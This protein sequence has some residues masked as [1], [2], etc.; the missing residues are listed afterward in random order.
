[1]TSIVVSLVALVAQLLLAALGFVLVFEP[2]AISAHLDLGTTPTWEGVLFALPIAMIGF[3]GLDSFANLGE[4]LDKPS[5]DIPRPLIWSAVVSVVVFVVMS[6]V[7]LNAQP[8]H[9][10]GTFARTELGASTG[11]VDR[12]VMG[13][14]DA[15]GVSDGLEGA[16]RTLFG[17]LAGAV[18]FLAAA[19]AIAA[20]GRVAWFMSRH[21]QAPSVLFS[22]DRRTGVPRT[23]IALLTLV[24]LGLL[25]TTIS[26]S[27]SAVVL[28]QVYAFGATFTATLAGVAIIRLRWCEPDLERPFRAPGNV[29][30]RGRELP[31]LLLAG[32]V[33]SGAMWIIVIATHDAAR[34]VGIGWMVLGFVCYGTYRLSHGL[35]LARRTD[36]YELVPPRIDAHAY[37][38]VLVA[39]RPERGL[40]YGAG[41]AELVGLADKLLDR[42][43]DRTIDIAV[44]LVHE[45]PL[46]EPLDAPLGE[47]EQLTMRRLALIRQVAD[48]LGL[49]VSSTVARARAAGRAICQEAR[50]RDIDA[51][52][53]GTRSR[54]RKGDVFGRTVAYVLRHAPCDVLVLAIPE[55]TLRRAAPTSERSKTLSR[56]GAEE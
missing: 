30:V 53:I 5:R 11:W 51:V 36:P 3:T 32:V 15:L 54:T 10:A 21:R 47:I 45:L 18:L 26:V 44:M 34:V 35:P 6:V 40:L 8:V 43:A 38:K 17:L 13:I 4:E 20:L 33:G 50:R 25:A 1:M 12:P 39:V 14:I 31:V 41:D 16:M 42:P 48:R 22:I 19:S 49:R 55:E 2:N 23:A 7:A 37:R 52:I 29:V 24:A 28:A 9:S 46:S 27:D 56:T